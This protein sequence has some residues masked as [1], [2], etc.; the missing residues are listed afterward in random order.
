MVTAIW[1]V[2]SSSK[3]KTTLRMSSFDAIFILSVLMPQLYPNQMALATRQWK[4]KWVVVSGSLPQSSHDG[5]DVPIL[6]A[7]LFLVGR[8]LDPILHRSILILSWALIF[9]IFCHWIVE[10]P[11]GGSWLA[12]YTD[13]TKNTPLL[14]GTSL[15]VLLL[16]EIWIFLIALTVSKLNKI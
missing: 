8:A 3:F 7:K 10:L 16:R 1:S 9:H 14:S 5:S 11:Q 13:F 12:L 4:N 15:S 2:L 6:N